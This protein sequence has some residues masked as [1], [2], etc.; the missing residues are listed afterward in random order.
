MQKI[1]DVAAADVEANPN[2]TSAIRRR[3]WMQYQFSM[4]VI[5]ENTLENAKR[6]G[7]LN[8]KEL[9]PDISQLTLENFA[10]DFYAMEDPGVEY[11]RA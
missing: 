7:Y 5:G 9:Y 1:I 11:K 6:L 4:H 10:K 8:A 3:G 2:D